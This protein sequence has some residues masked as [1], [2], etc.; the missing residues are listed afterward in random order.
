MPPV[1]ELIEHRNKGQNAA[2]IFV[3]G[4]TGKPEN[5]WADFATFIAAEKAVSGWDLF[6]VGYS[7]NLRIDLAGIWSADPDL[8]MVATLLD[9]TTS[10]TPLDH[11]GALS[12]IAH[13]MGG[14]AVQRALLDY[15]ELRARVQNVILFGTP[16]RGL[17]KAGLLWRLKRQLRDMAKGGR[18]VTKLRKDWSAQFSSHMPFQFTAVA[19]ENDEFVPYESSLGPFDKSVHASVAGNHLDIIR[20]RERNNRGVQLVVNRLS[21][22]R[23]Q[24]GPW[25]SARLAVEA[26]EFRKAVDLFE[27]HKDQLD[28]AAA[29]QLAIALEKCGRQNDAIDLLRARGKPTTDAM[30]TLAGRLKRRWLRERREDDGM[31]AME[32][33]SQ[34]HGLSENSD[35]AQAYYH[36]IN[37][38]F[39]KL[40]FNVSLPEAQI[41]ARRALEHCS[42]AA[43]IEMVPDAWRLATQGEA[44]LLIGNF[45]EALLLYRE[46]IATQPDPWQLESMYLQALETARQL[47]SRKVAADLAQTF[48]K[49]LE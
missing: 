33:Y 9:T 22:E 3:H 29:V 18:F 35:P 10:V 38:A 30:G 1:T 44:N 48:N 8:D 49:M 15:A 7:T 37:I 5:T 20:P 12:I 11:Y 21:G 17:T 40:V 25:D 31:R 27:P 46:A 41:W 26:R 34:A 23:A 43:K 2:V 39:L 36:A 47:K 42:A 28:D 16:S 4:F 24:I 32:L 6:S 13:S 45:P 14:L 19:G